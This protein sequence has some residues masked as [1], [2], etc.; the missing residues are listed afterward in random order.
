M[1]P[2]FFP[3]GFGGK[4]HE[5]PPLVP[6]KGGPM[7]AQGEGLPIVESPPPPKKP[8]ILGRGKGTLSP[9]ECGVN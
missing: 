7:P 5:G 4:R 1:C 3:L 2:Y 9:C 6:G 8:S